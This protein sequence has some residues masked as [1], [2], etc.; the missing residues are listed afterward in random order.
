MAYSGWKTCLRQ[1]VVVPEDAEVLRLARFKDVGQLVELFNNG[2]ASPFSVD[3]RGNTL[4]H[5]SYAYLIPLTAPF[6]SRR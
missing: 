4:L 2:E 1:Y 6:Q 5:V 3:E